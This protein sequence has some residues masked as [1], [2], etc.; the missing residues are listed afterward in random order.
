MDD[1]PN[2]PIGD[3]SPPMSDPIEGPQE[4]ALVGTDESN[5]YEPMKDDADAREYFGSVPEN[6]SLN[7]LLMLRSGN[8]ISFDR[9]DSLKSILESTQTVIPLGE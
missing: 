7:Y 6:E 9:F 5:F 2:L 3:L 8:Y 4:D 1:L